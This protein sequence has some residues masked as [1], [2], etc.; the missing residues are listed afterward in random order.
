MG[1][2]AHT[3]TKPKPKQRKIEND[4]DGGQNAPENKRNEA[5]TVS[6]PSAGM[7]SFFNISWYIS[8]I[9]SMMHGFGD[10]KKPFLE[11]AKLIERIVH[12]QMTSILTQASEIAVARNTKAIGIEELLFVLRKDRVKLSR[13]INYITIRDVKLS[14]TKQ[15]ASDAAADNEEAEG[16]ST[17]HVGVSNV[18][19]NL[20]RTCQEFLQSIDQTGE[21]NSIFEGNVFDAVKHERNLR[22]DYLSRSMTPE[23]YIHFCEARRA[24]FA[25]KYRSSKF[26][27]WLLRSNTLDI[28]PNAVALEI[29][30]YFAYET[31]AQIVDLALLLKKDV[32]PCD[33]ELDH[34]VSCH[35]LN[36][37]F[38]QIQFFNNSSP[39]GSNQQSDG[40]TISTGSPQPMSPNSGASVTKLKPKKRNRTGSMMCIEIPKTQ[41][42]LPSDIR[43]V[44]SRYMSP[45]GP[46]VYFSNAFVNPHEKRLFCS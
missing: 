13:L 24:S 41:S 38:P 23:H 27:D 33:D 11:S 14:S 15:N 43:D 16:T 20:R 28:K 46:F 5:T 22:A 42:I 6:D 18:K 17:D 34:I 32:Q 36:K 10:C 29:L 7:K 39:A 9:Q 21:L 37:D 12:Q 25:R 31:V 26:R 4:T 1:K 3:M 44:V 35:T 45:N 40:T 2:T 30:N 19:K 8:E